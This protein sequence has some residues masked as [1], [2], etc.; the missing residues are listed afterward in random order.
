MALVEHADD[1]ELHALVGAAILLTVEEHAE[2]VVVFHLVHRQ[3]ESVTLFE[4]LADEEV[5]EA[6]APPAG[7]LFLGDEEHAGPAVDE[8]PRPAASGEEL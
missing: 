5:G 3:D 7:L 2:V 6:A 4:G 1:L 8:L